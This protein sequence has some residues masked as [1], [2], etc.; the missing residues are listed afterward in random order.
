MKY[1][2]RY[3][4]E[5]HKALGKLY[6]RNCDFHDII[7]E[8]CGQRK[9]LFELN[10]KLIDKNAD[11]YRSDAEEMFDFYKRAVD[12]LKQQFGIE[13]EAALVSSTFTK[14]HKYMST[15]NDSNDTHDLIS[16]IVYKLFNEFKESFESGVDCD[17]QRLAKASA[18]YQVSH[19]INSKSSDKYY[20]FPW[21]VSQYLAKLALRNG[22]Q[23]HDC[24]QHWDELM[25]QSKRIP[26]HCI[27]QIINV[28]I[29]TTH[30]T[31]KFNEY[32]DR[33]VKQLLEKYD[34]TDDRV[35]E[36]III[37]LFDKLI[38]IMCDNNDEN[39]LWMHNDVD[40]VSMAA[41]I[42]KF[43]VQAIGLR[44]AVAHQIS[45]RTNTVVSA[46]RQVFVAKISEHFTKYFISNETTYATF[47][48][49]CVNET[50]LTPAFV[51]PTRAD[52]GEASVCV[53]GSY[54]A[55][56][57]FRKWFIRTNFKGL[58]REV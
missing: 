14:T 4:Y 46:D 5:S 12:D 35:S 11:Q 43:K 47:V 34:T 37:E 52:K 39:D 54:Q 25:A 31:Q 19:D 56:E 2:E 23:R 48:D 16:N 15:H 29:E 41:L 17:D 28:F 7:T 13:S 1:S 20:G 8:F 22:S 24:T 33:I 36:T 50:G 58:R 32:I 30:L 9:D 38:D 3:T 27:K 10:P 55:V 26:K 6:Q 42:A 57:R 53:Y 49:N 40:K 44:D 45:V 51:W 21:I 18:W